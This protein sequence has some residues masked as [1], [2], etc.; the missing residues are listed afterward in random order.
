MVFNAFYCIYVDR[1]IYSKF[2][3]RNIIYFNILRI[4]KTGM[5]YTSKYIMDPL[6]NLFGYFIGSLLFK[7]IYPFS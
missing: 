7:T 2:I 5:G 1:I 6:T 3:F 4:D